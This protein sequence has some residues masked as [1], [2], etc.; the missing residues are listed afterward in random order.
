MIYLALSGVVNVLLNLIFVIVFEMDVAGVAIATV[1]SQAMSAVLVVRCLMKEKGAFKLRKR[2]LIRIL[3][4][5]HPNLG[6]Q[7]PEL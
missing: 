1:I 2:T 6:L 3:P 5:E 7:P 4:H